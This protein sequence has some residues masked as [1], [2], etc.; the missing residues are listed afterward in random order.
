MTQLPRTP[1]NDFSDE[2][3]EKNVDFSSATMF[4]RGKFPRTGTD[5]ERNLIF[6]HMRANEGLN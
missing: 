3:S 6:R 2:V 5:I 4:S 1:K